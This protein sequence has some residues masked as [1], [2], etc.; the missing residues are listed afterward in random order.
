MTRNEYLVYRGSNSLNIV[1]QYYCEKFNQKKHSPLLSANSL[2][3]Y[4]SATGYDINEIMGK[5]L[6]YFDQK[7]SIITL[8][9]RN[10]RIIKFI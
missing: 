8:M 5:C 7:F 1:Y 9:D 4:L 3:Q 10:N 6:D 2:V